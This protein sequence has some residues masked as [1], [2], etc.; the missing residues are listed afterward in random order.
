MV[1]RLGINPLA[2][3]LWKKIII[4]SIA[5]KDLFCSLNE[6]KDT[7]DNDEI[8]DEEKGMVIVLMINTAL[9]V[10]I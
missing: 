4:T 6:T 5:S 9:V 10:T 3:Q 7:S 1:K 2:L 8:Q